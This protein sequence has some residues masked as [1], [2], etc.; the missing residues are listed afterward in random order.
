MVID[1]LGFL[2]AM[3]VL[4]V[5]SPLLLWYVVSWWI[6]RRDRAR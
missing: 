5:L 1:P 6:D 3:L 4:M 2:V